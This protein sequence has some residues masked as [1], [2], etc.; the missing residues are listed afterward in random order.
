MAYATPAARREY[1]RLWCAKNR[2]D[3]MT[4]KSC[5]VCGS[6]SSL[7]VDHIDPEQKVSH[8]IWSWSAERR[9]SELAKCQILCADHHKEKTRE[10][11]PLPEHGTISRYGSIHKCRC[12]LCRTANAERS[13]L[14][15]AKKIER[16][17]TEFRTN[18][19]RAA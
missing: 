11:R 15:K 2:A 17:L 4:G 19:K 1:Q 3:Y 13:A 10:Q 5:A 7:E 8:R 9:A 18:Y 12:E 6:T 16:E 14:N